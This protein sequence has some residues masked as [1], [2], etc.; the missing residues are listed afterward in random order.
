MY[1]FKWAENPGRALPSPQPSRLSNGGP[2][3]Q[4]GFDAAV[5]LVIRRRRTSPGPSRP[6]YAHRGPASPSPP[7]RACRT[8][9]VA[10]LSVAG[11]PRRA[12]PFLVPQR[13]LPG[14]VGA[15][16]CYAARAP[17]VPAYRPHCAPQKGEKGIPFPSFAA[18]G[19]RLAAGSGPCLLPV[20]LHGIITAWNDRRAV[21][22]FLAG[23]PLFFA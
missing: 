8:S 5:R 14:G 22:L 2:P 23:P 9:P 10:A 16:S 15:V 17:Q 12:A 19:A 11:L 7:W 20:F 3:N 21:D 4:T 13:V 18:P 1:I 6:M